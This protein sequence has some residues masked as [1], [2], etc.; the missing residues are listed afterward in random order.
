VT[1]GRVDADTQNLGVGGAEAV[2]QIFHAG[3]LRAS[4]GCEVEGVE[5][6]HDV[7]PTLELIETDLPR[8]LILKREPGRGLSKIDHHVLLY[9][10]RRVL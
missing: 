1:V 7:P 4:R 9:L 3:D 2:E 6:Q 10:S 5:E 8:K